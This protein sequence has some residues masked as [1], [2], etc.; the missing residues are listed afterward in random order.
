MDGD[1]ESKAIK[2]LDP[3]LTGTE[4]CYTTSFNKKRKTFFGQLCKF[5][6]EELE[7]FNETVNKYCM[8]VKKRDNDANSVKVELGDVV[9][10]EFLGTWYRAEV[11]DFKNKGKTC[12]VKFI[13]YGNLADVDPKDL[14]YFNKKDIPIIERSSFGITYSVDFTKDYNDEELEKLSECLVSDYCM[15]KV[16]GRDANN[17]VNVSI[18]RHG[19]NRGIWRSLDGD[20]LDRSNDDD[21][22]SGSER[23]S[24][25]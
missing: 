19:Y 18:P 6:N 23:S 17:V 5:T 24:S 14:V 16:L 10:S 7:E 9:G 22:A 12:R 11:V 21:D 8:Q 2:V 25:S 3:E 1:K 13:D 4:L 15:I 20:K